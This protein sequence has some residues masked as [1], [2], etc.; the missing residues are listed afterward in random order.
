MNAM[1]AIEHTGHEPAACQAE[2]VH[3]G[4]SERHAERVRHVSRRRIGHSCEILEG[5]EPSV[6]HALS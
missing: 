4:G 3:P 1:M 6:R 2:K 5:G